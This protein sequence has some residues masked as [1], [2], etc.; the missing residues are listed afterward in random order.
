[1]RK[2]TIK[3]YLTA[4][5]LTAFAAA[6]AVCVYSSPASAMTEAQCSAMGGKVWFFDFTTYCV[7]AVMNPGN[8]GV[9]PKQVQSCVD[10]HKFLIR[11][12]NGSLAC[13]SAFLTADQKATDARV[14]R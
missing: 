3:S 12:K 7:F 1:M 8:P 13:A 10:S 2:S 9:L 6:G 5:A 4:G 11:Q 14:P